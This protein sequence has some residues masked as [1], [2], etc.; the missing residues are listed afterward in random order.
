MPGKPIVVSYAPQIELLRRSAVA[1]THAGLNTILEALSFGVPLLSIPTN[2]GDQAG[3]AARVLYH[4]VGRVL[5]AKRINSR[6]V[7]GDI[8][9]L[10]KDPDYREAAQRMK[11]AIAC[12]GGAAEAAKLICASAY[13]RR[14]SG[15]TLKGA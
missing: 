3:N 9:S 13:S 2:A 4:G 11:A 14:Y 10:L 1:V 7:R 8:L 5:S 12:T 6:Q 15:S